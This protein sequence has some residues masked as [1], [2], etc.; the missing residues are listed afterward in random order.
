M[1]IATTIVLVLNV[2]AIAAAIWTAWTV[3]S[4]LHRWV[5]A[6]ISE[7][8]RKQDDRIRKQ[9]SRMEGQPLDVLPTDKD[10][11][12]FSLN[13]RIGQPIRRAQNEP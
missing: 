5:S 11:P 3:R 10:N 4:H 13:Y 1:G 7:E 12:N 6:A 8:I 9:L 2:I